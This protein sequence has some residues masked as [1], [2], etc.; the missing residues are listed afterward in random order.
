MF[1]KDAAEERR[2]H[3]SD[4]VVLAPDHAHE[5]YD[6]QAGKAIRNCKIAIKR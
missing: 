4:D 2:T 5:L 1:E 6:R 3:S